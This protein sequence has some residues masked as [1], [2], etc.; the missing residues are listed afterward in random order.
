MDFEQAK[1][2]FAENF[3]NCKGF[4]DLTLFIDDEFGF[5]IK[6]KLKSEDKENVSLLKLYIAKKDI[7]DGKEKKVLRISVSYGKDYK[8]SI[9]R[10]PDNIKSSD[11]IDLI[12]EDEYYYSI[13]D[14]KFFVNKFI[15]GTREIFACDILTGIYSD[16]VKSTKLLKG[17]W[18]RS[19][20]YFWRVIVKYSFQF[21]SKLFYYCLYIISG[22]RYIYDPI[23]G[24]GKIN[25]RITSSRWEDI[26]PEPK[27][28]LESGDKIN[29]FGYQAKTHSVI[30]YSSLHLVIY[31][32]FE[33]LKYKPEIITTI[34]K[35]NFLTLMYVICSLWIIEAAIP[36]ILIYFIKSSSKLSIESLYRKIRI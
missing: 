2:K 8:S 17:F 9:G 7:E 11:P 29:V 35:N 20:L 34:F 36:K 12:S 24:E 1:N 3:K 23:S 18:L 32:I 6:R 13:N 14:N 21:L 30:V 19:K 26:S 22:D 4:Y 33:T 16:H 31:I 5:S 15:I 28:N 25:G 27:E 10:N